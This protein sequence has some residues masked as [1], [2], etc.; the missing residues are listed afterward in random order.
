MQG[1]YHPESKYGWAVDDGSGDQ[2]YGA[3]VNIGA[4]SSGATI[5]RRKFGKILKLRENGLLTDFNTLPGHV[6]RDG[7]Y[8]EVW[9]A[10]YKEPSFEAKPFMATFDTNKP[11]NQ[12][13]VL[14]TV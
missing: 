11:V 3:E 6:Q 2:V 4:P 12:G 7:V 1:K 9:D 14:R 8:P 10:K 13:A 5:R